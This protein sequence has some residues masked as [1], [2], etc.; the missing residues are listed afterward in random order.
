MERAEG[1]RTVTSGFLS[2]PWPADAERWT[3]P[4]FLPV[5]SNGVNAGLIRRVA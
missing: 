4:S 1:E 3:G 2:P 5:S